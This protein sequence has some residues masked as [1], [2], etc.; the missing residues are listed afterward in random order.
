MSRCQ[1][2]LLAGSRWPRDRSQR[3]AESGVAFA[4]RHT[5]RQSGATRPYT[6][7]GSGLRRPRDATE[8]RLRRGS[9]RWSPSALVVRSPNL[10]HG[11][12]PS[13]P[14]RLAIFMIPSGMAACSVPLDEHRGRSRQSCRASMYMLGKVRLYPCA[15]FGS[16]RRT[17]VIK[18]RVRFE[19]STPVLQ[20]CE[21]SPGGETTCHTNA[22][23]RFGG[24]RRPPS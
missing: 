12:R 7:Q 19:Q 23:L 10:D 11:P 18:R 1:Q 20:S 2:T 5:S 16:S 8:S 13:V 22:G 24:T 3:E 15:R 9:R 21:R 14:I 4:R 17:T 6:G